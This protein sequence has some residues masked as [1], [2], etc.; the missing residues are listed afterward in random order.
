MSP[1]PGMLAINAR[2]TEHQAMRPLEAP[3]R[4]AVSFR[5]VSPTIAGKRINW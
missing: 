3:L 2:I 1:F 4:L 5:I